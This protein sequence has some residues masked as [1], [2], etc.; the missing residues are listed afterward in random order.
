MEEEDEFTDFQS[1]LPI[2]PVAFVEPLKPAVLEPV[3]CSTAPTTINWPDPGVSDDDLRNFELFYKPNVE[4]TA[5]VRE[6]PSKPAEDDEW[7]DFVS[8]EPSNKALNQVKQPS[9]YF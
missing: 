9:R 1:T 7:S 4:T 8:S 2:Q 3:I 6:G 5:I